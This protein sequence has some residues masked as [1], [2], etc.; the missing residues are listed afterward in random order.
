[1]DDISIYKMHKLHVLK[2]QQF[3]KQRLDNSQGDSGRRLHDK[4]VYH[5]RC[6]HNSLFAL[7]FFFL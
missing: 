3:K 6:C 5:R 4:L 7:F 1:M 2:A